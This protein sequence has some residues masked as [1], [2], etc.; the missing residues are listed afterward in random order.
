MKDLLTRRALV[1]GASAALALMTAPAT[2]AQAAERAIKWRNW[3]G[4]LSSQPAQMLAPDSEDAVIGILR[5]SQGIIRPAGAAHSWSGL[6]PTDGN[7]ITL[8]R[9]SGL[10][11]HDP[12]TL[13][14]EVWAGTRLFT[15]GPLLE[16]IGQA[17]VNMSD[18]NYQSL[19]GA[20]STSTH[21][22]GA[23]LGSM[24][25]YVCGLRLVTPSGDVVDCSEERDADLFNAARTSLGA[26]GVITRLRF[27]NRESHRLHQREWLADTEE[28]LEDI[29]R[30][31]TQNDLFELFPLPNSGRTIVVTTNAAEAGTEDSIQDDPTALIDLK[32]A[33]ELIQKLPVAEEFVYDQALDFAFGD[34]KDRIGP[35][36]QVL[37]H[38]RTVPFMEMEYTV[39]A[40]QGVACLREV[41]ATIRQHAPEVCFPL[42]YRYIKGDDTLIGM[43]SGQ[44]GCAI[45]VHQYADDP[46]WERY[47]ALVEPVFHKYRGR[48]HWGKWH[49]L[50]HAQLS[51]LYP[52]WETFGRIRTE[53]DPGNRM[54]NPYLHQLL[55]VS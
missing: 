24:S 46:D 15:F 22:T 47:L 53:L 34:A 3:G 8:D 44:D 1:K 21:G 25:S 27:Q 39:P 11:D 32:E 50:D 16:G 26:L 43:F 29:E 41:L 19:A 13:Q 23:Q 55:G 38:P 52:Q 36:Y 28:V 40:D 42:E 49:S 2:L 33:F 9:L 7:M 10:I 4:N 6:V 18:I 14:A 45:S 48:P 35:S 37:A 30:L 20:I 5:E 12:D 31:N 17:V 54:L 51:A